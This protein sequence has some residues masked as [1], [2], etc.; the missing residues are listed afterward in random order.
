MQRL[1]LEKCHCRRKKQNKS[2]NWNSFSLAEVR[3]LCNLK[4]ETVGGYTFVRDDPESVAQKK[5]NK[6]TQTWNYLKRFYFTDN[7]LLTVWLDVKVLVFQ[8]LTPTGFDDWLGQLLAP[9]KQAF[10]ILKISPEN[11]MLRFELQRK[12]TT[13]AR[14]YVK[15]QRL[16][17]T[18]NPG[19]GACC[20]KPQHPSY[21]T[22]MGSNSLCSLTE[23]SI[24]SD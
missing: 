20:F 4:Q 15:H 22:S 5:E 16:F 18:V 24:C 8:A 9:A 10:W 6:R 17:S 23:R 12:T 3:L 21:K 19:D 14:A 11:E 7:Y 1:L 13:L 2:S